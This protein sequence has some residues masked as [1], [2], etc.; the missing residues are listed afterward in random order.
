[1]LEYLESIPLELRLT[2]LSIWFSGMVSWLVVEVYCIIDQDKKFA[3]KRK[4]DHKKMLDE[5]FKNR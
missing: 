1:M 3:L 4:A 2:F 5:M